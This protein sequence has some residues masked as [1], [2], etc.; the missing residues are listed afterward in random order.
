VV[1]FEAAR[2][3]VARGFEVKG[4]ILIDSPNPVEHEPLPASIISKIIQPSHQPLGPPRKQTALEREFLYNASLLGTYKPEPFCSINRRKLKTV[5]LRSRDIF[6]SET[7]CGV[8]YD[9]LSRQDT[10]TAAISAWRD[11]VG[12]HVHVM[13]I[14]GNHFEPFLEGNVSP[15]PPPILYLSLMEIADC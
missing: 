8:R 1:A 7:L 14:P 11:L 13:S 5:M 2:Q 3:L 6:N 10:R 15:T 4:L 12:G 9:W